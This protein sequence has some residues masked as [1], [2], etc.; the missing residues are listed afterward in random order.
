M[1]SEICVAMQRDLFDIHTHN[2]KSESTNIYSVRL[3]IEPIPNGKVCSAGVHPWDIGK[4]DYQ[5]QIST[6]NN[7]DIVAVG[8]CGLDYSISLDRDIQK[9]VFEQHI[10]IAKERDLPIIIHSVKALVDVI[11]MLKNSDINTAIF[12]SFIGS[13]EQAKEIIRQGWYLSLGP[14]SLQSSRCREIIK[15]AD[16]SSIFLESDESREDILEVYKDVA[17]LRN[18]TLDELK[19]SIKQNYIKIFESRI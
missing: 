19:H 9:S 12:H 1:S 16:L 18:T 17:E 13:A 6:L 11:K 10:K 2:P 5:Q 4:V 15:T 7:A 8:E 3:G 14:R